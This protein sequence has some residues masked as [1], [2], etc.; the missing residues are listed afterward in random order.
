MDLG[1][2]GKRAL[3]AAASRGLGAAIAQ[4]LAEEGCAV[5]ICSRSF[6]E[7][8]ST[9]ASIAAETGGTVTASEVDVSDGDAIRRWVDDAARRLGGIDI[10]I[11]NAGGPPQAVFDD[12]TPEAWDAAYALTLRSAMMFARVS[13]PHMS[14]GGSMLYLTST[15]SKVPISQLSL[16][17]VFRSGVSALAK[18]LSA[19]WAATGIRVNHLIPGKIATDRLIQLDET[20]ASRLGISFQEARSN[21]EASIPL[22]RYGEPHEFASAAAFLV[23]PRAS[24]ITGATLQ[25]DGG[26]IS[27]VS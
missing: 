2:E 7:A 12:T 14:Q 25:V 3:V 22:G 24:Y 21:S 13:R 26:A 8:S 9:A 19:D 15:S 1:L 5:E 6:A 27:S 20:M 4:T 23:S 16:S 11:P 10:V 18:T 17:G